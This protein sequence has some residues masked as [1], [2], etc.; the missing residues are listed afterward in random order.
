MKKKGP[1]D[2]QLP[3][4]PL[5]AWHFNFGHLVL[6]IIVLSSTSVLPFRL[7]KNMTWP[8]LGTISEV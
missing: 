1:D 3:V 4:Y 7:H 6:T 5:Q 8:H 2:H